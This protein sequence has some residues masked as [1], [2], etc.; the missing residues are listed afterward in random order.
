MGKIFSTLALIVS[1][2]VF[3][4]PAAHAQQLQ[5]PQEAAEERAKLLELA[6]EQLPLQTQSQFPDQVQPQAQQPQIQQQPALAAP[7]A[8]ASAPALEAWQTAGE[9]STVAPPSSQICSSD[10]QCIL[11]STS[12]DKSCGSVPMN[13]AFE[14][15]YM[16]GLIKRCGA[17]VRSLPKC[18][19]NPP[20]EA[21][22]INQRCT[23][24][25]PHLNTSDDGD[26]RNG[27]VQKP[28]R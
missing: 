16:Q 21:K 20:L 7:D 17:D 25:Y 5:T 13:K 15:T 8:S 18:N 10:A 11:V 24:S 14:D 6:R 22:C 1:L 28:V 27:G 4:V 9:Y 19:M 26:Y 23:L 3:A 12:C 2:T